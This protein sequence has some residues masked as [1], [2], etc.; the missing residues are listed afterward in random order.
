MSVVEKLLRLQEHDVRV[1]DLE[2]LKK[3]IPARKEAEQSRLNKHREA[4]AA[5]EEA[6][7]KEQ[8]RIKELDVESES[9]QEKIKKLR[10]QQLEIKTNKEFR[11]LESEITG[12]EDQITDIEDSELTMMEGVEAA[13]ADVAA[14]K[15]SLAEEEGSVRRDVQAW[16]SRLTEIQSELDSLSAVRSAAAAEVDQSWLPVYEAIFERKDR[17]LVRVED[18]VCGGCHMNLPRYLIHDAKKQTKL[19]KCGFCGRMLC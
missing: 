18:G 11:A 9:R 15:T 3:D 16:D 2:Q 14:K 12:L 8:A 4:L 19:L 17:A 6:L 13:K 10:T 5:A 1:R 7:K